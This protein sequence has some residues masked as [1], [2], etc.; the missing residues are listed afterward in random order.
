MRRMMTMTTKKVPMLRAQFN[1]LG[2]YAWAPPT[3]E[4]WLIDLDQGYMDTL[5]AVGPPLTTQEL[6]CTVE[7][8]RSSNSRNVELRIDPPDIRYAYGFLSR[9]EKRTRTII[10]DV[11]LW[12]ETFQTDPE[13]GFLMIPRRAS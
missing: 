3:Q 10:G 4:F 2:R 8:F 12:L 9:D 1:S 13:T 11:D 7:I 5:V 6:C